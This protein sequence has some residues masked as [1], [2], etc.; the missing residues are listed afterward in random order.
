MQPKTGAGGEYTNMKEVSLNS[1]GGQ[2]M[3][4]IPYFN[5]FAK[6]CALHVHDSAHTKWHEDMTDS[7]LG[8]RTFDFSSS[9]NGT[10]TMKS[11]VKNQYMTQ[12]I[13]ATGNFD[14]TSGLVV[15][16][17]EQIENVMASGPPSS[18]TRDFKLRQ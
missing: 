5:T 10:V 15:S 11:T 14:S 2:V 16:Y 6:G 12:T 18:T 3:T 8:Q 17:H 13:T 4:H 7:L 1:V 9:D